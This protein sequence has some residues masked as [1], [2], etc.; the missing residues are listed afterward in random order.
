[1]F[2]TI[3]SNIQDYDFLLLRLDWPVSPEF[4]DFLVSVFPQEQIINSPEGMILTGSKEFLLNFP[5]LCPAMKICE[6]IE[7][8]EEFKEEYPMVL[9]PLENYG[10]FGL[11][12]IENNEVIENGK[13]FN[14]DD[15]LPILREKVKGRYLAMKFLKNVTNGD[16]RVIVINGKILGATLRLPPSN[17]YICNLTQGGSSNYADVTKEETL[18]AKKISP[19]MIENGVLIFGFDTLEDDDGKRVLSEIKHT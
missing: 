14:Y 10:G 16:K 7:D 2:N 19:L 8:I 5:N 6:S 15:Y 13:K 3:I 17:S 11:I 12:K 1:M 18:I 4:L 9:K